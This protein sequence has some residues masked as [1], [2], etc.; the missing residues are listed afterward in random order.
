MFYASMLLNHE[1][2]SLRVMNK[3]QVTILY[4]SI[5]FR[6]F[7]F[8]SRSVHN[9]VETQMNDFP[10]LFNRTSCKLVQ[11]CAAVGSFLFY[12]KLRNTER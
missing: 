10:T 8:T 12:L 6:H 4:S 3:Y 7:T 2:T 11:N 9:G 5:L 1:P